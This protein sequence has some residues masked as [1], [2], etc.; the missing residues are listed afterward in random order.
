MTEAS[1]SSKSPNRTRKWLVTAAIAGGVAVGATGIAGAVSSSTTPTAKSGTATT[2]PSQG[3][4]DATH[5]KGES[6]QREADEK[7]GKINFGGHGGHGD[8][9][10]RGDH[11][12]A[13][14]VVTGADA[15]KANAAA[16]ASVPG[17]VSKTEKRADGTYEVEITKADGTEVHVMLDAAFKVTGQGGHGGN[18][19]GGHGRHHD[20]NDTDGGTATTT[21]AGAAN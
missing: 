16:L 20:G 17:K 19:H 14:T 10:W 12:G 4:E 13:E 6:A 7:A 18:G 21:A 5:E 2:V 8:H 15:D 3:N 11:G 1:K 9:G